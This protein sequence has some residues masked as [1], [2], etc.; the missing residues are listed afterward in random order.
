MNETLSNQTQELLREEKIITDTEVAIS[1]G[2]KYVAENILTKTRR[3]I[4]VP[5]RLIESSTNRR[6][7]KG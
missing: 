6:V 2:D 4:H 1:I 3:V 7:L 5:Q